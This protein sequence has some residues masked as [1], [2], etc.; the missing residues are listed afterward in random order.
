[1]YVL[2][3]RSPPSWS[4]SRKSLDE[5]LGVFKA[6]ALANLVNRQAPP[7]SPPR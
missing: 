5:V 4:L 7:T 6:K 1:M 2:L 3:R